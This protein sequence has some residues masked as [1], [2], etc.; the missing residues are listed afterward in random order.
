MDEEKRLNA[1]A[2]H[3]LD[4][5]AFASSLVTK[6]E[7]EK[8]EVK[9]P[10]HVYPRSKGE[11]D[12]MAALLKQAEMVADD[13]KDE[14]FAQRYTT[15]RGIVDWSLKRHKTW[16]W[17]LVIAA[18]VGAAVLYLVQFKQ[19]EDILQARADREQVVQWK[20]VDVNSIDFDVCPT[21]QASDGYAMRLVSADRYKTYKLIDLKGRALADSA[22]FVALRSSY[23]S[24]NAMDFEQIHEVALNDLDEHV[25]SKESWGTLLYAYMVFLLVLIPVYIITGYPHGYTITRRNHRLG[26]LNS[27]RK[28]GIAVALFCLG[29][30]VASTLLPDYVS[31][32]TSADGQTTEHRERK[33]FSGILL[34]LRLILMIVGAVLLCLVASIVMTVE[35]IGGVIDMFKKCE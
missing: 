18:L 33:W 30:S 2:I 9:D 5:A 6:K 16:Q 4:E 28:I 7:R 27:F 17:T 31:R 11:A 8:G 32:N 26:C 35:S 23:D 24:I 22:Q 21:K 19:Q 29:A 25:G 10:S 34:V 14:S 13:A 15:L 12:Q 20:T 1:E 3:Y